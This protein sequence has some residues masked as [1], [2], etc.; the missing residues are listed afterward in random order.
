MCAVGQTMLR[1]FDSHQSLVW[2]IES[3]GQGEVKI[4]S[5]RCRFC[6]TARCRK[7]CSRGSSPN[8]VTLSHVPDLPPFPTVRCLLKYL[9]LLRR[10]SLLYTNPKLQPRSPSEQLTEIPLPQL[11][12]PFNKPSSASMGWFDDSQSQSLPSSTLAS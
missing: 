12:R 1:S 11:L 2:K 10:L 4:V 3:V 7:D 5:R 9:S 8:I 6:D